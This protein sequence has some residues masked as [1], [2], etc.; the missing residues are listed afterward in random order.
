ML[1][2]LLFQLAKT[3][4][5]VLCRCSCHSHT[6]NCWFANHSGSGCS[7]CIADVHGVVA[8]LLFFWCRFLD[9][10]ATHILAFEGDSKVRR[11]LHSTVP[12]AAPCR[13]K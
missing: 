4:L 10:V 7:A 5:L 1:L 2:L 8:V 11:I 6:M 3:S 9:R 12:D 13:V